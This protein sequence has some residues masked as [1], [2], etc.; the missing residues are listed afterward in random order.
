MIQLTDDLRATMAANLARH[1]R[2]EI[3]LEGR[4]HAAVAILVVDSHA[5]SDADD[6]HQATQEDMSV[7]PSDTSGLDGRCRSITAPTACARAR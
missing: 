2:T 6:P 1:E 5:G 7:I 4:R 3:A